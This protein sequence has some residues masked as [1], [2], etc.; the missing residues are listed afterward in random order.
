M[1]TAGGL[2]DIGYDDLYRRW[3]RGNWSATAIDF[4][5]DREQWRTELTDVERRAAL[6]NFAMFFHGEDSV[7]GG[8]SPYIHAAPREEQKYFLATQQVDEARHA[9]FFG[10]FLRDVMDRGDG[11]EGSLAATRDQLTW[12]FRHVF[13]RLERM[14]EEL[15]RDP[16]P[17]MLAR[18]IVLYH[19][20]IEGALAQPGQHLIERWLEDRGV[21]PG[22]LSGI[23]NVA[24]DE[25]RHIGFGV[26]L[27]S[28]LIADPECRAAALEML[29]EVLRFSAAVFVPP[30]WD[31]SY[32]EPFGF[33]LEEIYAEGDRSITTKLRSA[34]FTDEEIGRTIGI[35]LDRAPEERAR[36]LVALLEAGVI[37][38]KTGPPRADPEVVRLLFDGME[39]AFDPDKAP[40]RP[41]TI[42]WDFKDV[43]PWHI[44]FDDG[45]TRAQPGRA[46]RADLGFRCTFEDWVD[47]AAGRIDPTLAM[48]RGRIRPSGLRALWRSR[49]LL[50]G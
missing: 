48:A 34:G 50:A 9:V 32:V 41:Y 6:W 46:A 31:R 22:F 14:G 1:A 12:G 37:G 42:E 33:T 47:V 45:A 23:R 28:E 4:D 3:E 10:R 43:G 21:L 40:W 44:V 29:A 49:Q 5:V 8:L 7:A 36:G 19:V 16:S 39:V 24:L 27:L 18:G 25:Q 13:E 26:K 35:H 17:A 11:Y 30:G 2:H 38:E 20:V 15:R